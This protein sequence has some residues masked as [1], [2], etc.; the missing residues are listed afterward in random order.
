MISYSIR[1]KGTQCNGDVKIVLLVTVKRKIFLEYNFSYYYLPS[2][3][4][5]LCSCRIKTYLQ[6]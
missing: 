3:E 2:T 4:N 5:G 1:Y 6:P